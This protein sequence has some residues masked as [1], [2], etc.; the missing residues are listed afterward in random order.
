M[1]E[2]VQPKP[3]EVKITPI[4]VLSAHGKAETVSPLGV[5]N[6]AE[7]KRG[8]EFGSLIKQKTKDSVNSRDTFKKM[9][10]TEMLGKPEDPYNKEQI[11]EMK[12]KFGEGEFIKIENGVTFEDKIAGEIAKDG[13]DQVDKLTNFLDYTAI[14][15]EINKGRSLEDVLKEKVITEADWKLKRNAALDSILKNDG[16][17]RVFPFLE[18]LGE[19]EGRLFI[20]QTIATDP[21]LQEKIVDKMKVMREQVKKL[22]DVKKEQNGNAVEDS[23]VTRV[24]KEGE[25]VGKLGN[26]LPEAVIDV[27][28]ERY[29]KVQEVATEQ[30]QKETDESLLKLTQKMDKN[31]ISY[32]RASRERTVE[33]EKIG[34]D[35][36]FLAYHGEKGLDRLIMRDLELGLYDEQGKPLEDK[37]GFAITWENADKSQLSSHDKALFDKASDKYGKEY[38]KKLLSDFGIARATEKKWLRGVDKD[39]RLKGF[40]WTLLNQNF[41]DELEKNV[42]KS[43]GGDKIMRELKN[44]GVDK[45]K[46]KAGWLMALLLL[47]GVGIAGVA[48]EAVSAE[49][50]DRLK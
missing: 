41:G 8:K 28:A 13:K 46:D 17:K 31:W 6:E 7:I 23:R 38:Q 25:L 34:E 10:E 49:F 47:L 33:A 2:A 36:R 20:E 42:A 4:E 32:D 37:D 3:Q 24:A 39:L 40:E 22:P 12:N 18:K 35:I 50:S 26:V 48:K 1:S 21:A 45:Q 5:I 44:S 27:I 16:F 15:A 29:A 43:P 14:S 11:D 9:L 30:R 19:T